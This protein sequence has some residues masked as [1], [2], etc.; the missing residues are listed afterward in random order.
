[1]VQIKEKTESNTFSLTGDLSNLGDDRLY[2]AYFINEYGKLEVQRSERYGS[3]F[4]VVVIH[5]ESFYNGKKIPSRKGLQDFLTVLVKTINKVIRGC[6]I[7]GILEDKKIIII[8][9]HTAYFDSL[10]AIRK[11]THALEFCT[12]TEPF[13]TIL[14]SQATY[15]KDANGYGELV[16]VAT[17]RIKDRMN[18]L[19]ERPEFKEKLFW[20]MAA[21]L[22]GTEMTEAD[23]ATF[24]IGEEHDLPNSFIDTLNNTILQEVERNY[25]KRGILYMGVKRFSDDMPITKSIYSIN[26]TATRIYV[27]GQGND[28]K[29]EMGCATALLL[30]DSRLLNTYFTLF[31]NEDTAYAI[32]CNESWGDAHSCFHTSDPF[33]VEA[34]IEKFQKDYSL[35]ERL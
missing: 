30:S 14:F 19:L 10:I 25:R 6:D 15:P 29:N 7:S 16:T 13:A 3:P 34:L 26:K 12:K 4:S 22:T 35:Q 23:H 21:A 8:L 11:L 20:E 33:I 17:K 24:Y 27:V 18:S 1:M 31:L 2:D 5:V 9:P 28:E 32:F